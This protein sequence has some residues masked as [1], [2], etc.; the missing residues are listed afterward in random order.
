VGMAE[1]RY[2]E[3]LY[4]MWD[5]ILAAHPHLAIDNCASGGRRIDLETMSRSLP[6]WRS[7]NTCDMQDQK[8]A[9]V[10]LAAIKN[11]LISDGLNRYVPFSTC[12]Q[13]GATPY[14]FRSG[15][16]AGI[17]FCQDVRSEAYPRDLLQKGISEGKR[18]RK[19]FFGNYYPLV[20]SGVDPRGWTVLQYHRPGEKDG[21]LMA[22][23]RDQSGE[24]RCRCRLREIDPT[25]RYT[26]NLYRTYEL[27]ETATVMGSELQDLQVIISDRPGS[28]IIEYFE[29]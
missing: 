14:L 11:Q 3:G 5:D 29:C 18:I 8:P 27:E 9:T 10:E 12:G 6:L 13:M 4:R 24:S 19:Y 22:F 1:I 20:E 23:R 15:F 21:L 7:D 26:V 17:A 2:M 25:A 28:V 16:N